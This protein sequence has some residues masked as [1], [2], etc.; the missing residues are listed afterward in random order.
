MAFHPEGVPVT[1][2]AGRQL[3]A[4]QV[5]TEEGGLSAGT[6]EERHAVGHGRWGLV[7]RKHVWP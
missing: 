4:A 2:S 3:R 1:G 5:Q 7:P 6:H